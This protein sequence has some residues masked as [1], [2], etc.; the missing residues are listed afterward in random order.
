VVLI[1]LSAIKLKR[2]IISA[3]NNIEKNKK[4]VDEM[5]IFPVPDGDTGTNMFFT[6]NSAI[7]E[8]DSLNTSSVAQAS[9]FIS[10]HM[11][12]GSRGNSG[13]ILSLIFK[14][15]AKGLEDVENAD[16]VLLS[17]GLELGVK[18]AYD[19][20]INPTEGT[21]L[22]VVKIACEKG[23]ELLLKE[24]E[25]ELS[26][27]WTCVC[28]GAQEALEKTPQ[29]LPILKKVGVVDA[30]GK[31]LCLIFEGMLSVFKDDKIID[32][33][34]ENSEKT[35]F[36]GK[37]KN[38]E[39]SIFDFSDDLTGS[40]T[41]TYCTEFVVKK[42]DDEAEFSADFKLF[43][44]NIGDSVVVIEDKDIMKV[45]VH[46]DKPLLALQKALEIGQLLISKIENMREQNRLLREKS[47]K[48]NSADEKSI[49]SVEPVEEMGF[50]AVCN[51][52]GIQNMFCDLG[53]SQTVTGGQ[54]MN[55]ST[56]DIVK[57][58]LATPAK[59]VFVLPNNKNIILSANQVIPLVSDRR[60]I[61]VETKT[62]PQGISVMLAYNPDATVDENLE[63]MADSIKNVKT[64]QVTF[65]S[66]DAEFGGIKFKKDESIALFEGRLMFKAKDPVRAAL[67]LISFMVNKKTNFSTLIYGNGINKDQVERVKK[68]IQSRANSQADISVING[69][70]PVYHF[71]FSVE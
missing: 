47:G 27:F 68:K 57:A 11:L 46:T 62:I 38:V 70:Q 23:K 51:G 12:R 50:V 30:G 29:L 53:C 15:I 32:A 61:V 39:Q 49:K 6:I 48:N 58:V 45:H 2:A 69:G 9:L 28:N 20:V 5:N 13:T 37:Y 60:V 54:S 41:F 31:G 64:G 3:A 65:A 17:K 71:I 63:V 24:K 7:K 66:R 40:I 18:G 10:S 26:R 25:V 22:T 21:M 14:G 35:L 8:I 67:K 43:L 56:N 55:P 52:V 16:S 4:I 1:L 19:A 59:V 34:I 44:E 33:S 36:P 42:E